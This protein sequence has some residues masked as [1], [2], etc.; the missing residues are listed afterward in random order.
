M[1]LSIGLMLGTCPMLDHWCLYLCCQ[2]P[3]EAPLDKNH[4]QTELSEDQLQTITKLA[5]WIGFAKGS[6][7][8]LAL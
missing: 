8:A 3:H 7:L 5:A 4:E 1:Q 2:I 6:F